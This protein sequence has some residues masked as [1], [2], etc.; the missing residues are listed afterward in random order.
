[1]KTGNA[2][3]Q[4]AYAVLK[5][6]GIF[7]ILEQ[8]D[9]ILVGTIPININIENSD[10]DIICCFRD[11]SEFLEIMTNNFFDFQDFK[12]KQSNINDNI[13]IVVTFKVDEFELEVFGQN[14]PTRKQNAYRHMLIEHRLLTERG[15]IFRQKIIDLKRQGHKTEPAFGILLD[16]TGDPFSELLN[17]EVN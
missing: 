16:L 2:R 14:I 15:E 11:P 6:C 10:L 1:M 5:K 9:P 3:Q 8:F 17:Y 4:G 12:V 7:T 13:A